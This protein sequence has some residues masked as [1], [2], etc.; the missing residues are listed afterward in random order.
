MGNAVSARPTT[1]ID[2]SEISFVGED[3]ARPECVLCDEAGVLHVSDWRGGVTRIYPNGRQETTLARGMALRPNGICLLP[4]GNYLVAHLGDRDGGVFHLARSGK[5]EPFLTAIDNN[6]LPPTNYVYRDEL[7]RVWISVSTR[8]QPRSEAYRADV[9]DGFIISVVGSR[10]EIAAENLGYANECIIDPTGRWLYVNETFS[11]PLSR[12][13]VDDQDRLG[14]RETVAEFNWGIFPDGLT[15]DE[16]G[17][18]W[19]TSVISNTILRV[20]P[21]LVQELV[22]RDADDSH[23]TAAETA[24]K[25]RTLGRPHLDTIASQLLKNISSLSFGGPDRRTAYLGCLLGDR[26][27]C[28]RTLVAG[29]IPAH[30]HGTCPSAAANHPQDPVDG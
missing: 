20:D 25:D 21:S 11:K 2:L 24:F 4:D 22:L 26:I 29:A 30:W 16:L 23:V 6:P 27:A 9:R 18:I 8:K 5:I 10:A 1:L 15:F 7:G 12:F 28:F 3:L 17:G 19:I 14:D 13:A